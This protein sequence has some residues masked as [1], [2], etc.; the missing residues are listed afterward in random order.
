[1]TKQL[2]KSLR[3]A[4]DS[5]PLEGAGRVEDTFNLLGHAARKVVECAAAALQL[6]ARPS[7]VH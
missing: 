6:S 1:M 2:P 7:G 5:S 4:I 3:I